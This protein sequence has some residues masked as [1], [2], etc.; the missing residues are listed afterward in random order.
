MAQSLAARQSTQRSASVTDKPHFEEAA[1]R[2]CEEDFQAPAGMRGG[3]SN[4]FRLSPGRVDAVCMTVATLIKTAHRPLR[5]HSSPVDV[6]RLNETYGLGMEDGTRVRGGPDW[7][8][9]EKYAITAVGDAS[10]SAETLQRP[11]LMELL[12]RRIQLTVHVDVEQ[13]PVYVLTVAK[14][15]LKMKPVE[16]GSCEQRLPS[17]M[18]AVDGGGATIDPAARQR[19]MEEYRRGTLPRECGMNSSTS[20]PNVIHA[21][22]EAP[23]SQLAQRLSGMAR[24]TEGLDVRLVIDKTGLPDTDRFTFFLEYAGIRDEYSGPMQPGDENIPKGTSIF[25]ALERLGLHLEQVKDSREF[26]VIDHIE[27]PSDN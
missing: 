25:D 6:L 2:R 24:W 16:R 27:R 17:Y 5:N 4:S 18:R 21:A 19:Q 11:M 22:G 15:G 3:G 10:A 23:I 1:I 12:E 7:V 13:V 14:G 26:V 8:R 9:S 20:G